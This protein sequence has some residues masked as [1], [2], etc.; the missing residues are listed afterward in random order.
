MKAIVVIIFSCLS[1]N[2]FAQRAINSCVQ[3][4]KDFDKKNDSRP[5]PDNKSVYYVNYNQKIV[6]WDKS[7]PTVNTDVKIW[8]NMYRMKY[9]TPDIEVYQDNR[10]AFM[11][12]HSKKKIIWGQSEMKEGKDA[13]DQIAKI[14]ALKDTMLN[15]STVLKCEIFEKDGKELLRMIIKVNADVREIYNV[16]Q[17]EFIYDNSSGNIL[18]INTDFIPSY[19]AKRMEI[20]YLKNEYDYKGVKLDKPVSEKIVSRSNLLLPKYKEYQLIDNR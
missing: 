7:T 10:D 2:L 20:T 3:R 13:M 12:I 4:V 9:A 1:I 11:I 18:R 15:H 19:E 6:M 16:E 8:A 14:A 17:M 5:L